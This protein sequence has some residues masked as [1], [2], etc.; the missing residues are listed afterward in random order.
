VAKFR[1]SRLADADLMDIGAYT[2]RTWG[3]TQTI[4]YIDGLESCCQQLADIPE[5]GRLG[6]HPL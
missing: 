2:L 1:L 6:D 4:R 5:S 3:E